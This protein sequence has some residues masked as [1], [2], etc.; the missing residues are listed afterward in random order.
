MQYFFVMLV[1]AL[2]LSPGS[3]WAILNTEFYI[4]V[5]EGLKR[6]TTTLTKVYKHLVLNTDDDSIGQ[7]YGLIQLQLSSYENKDCPLTP[8]N[9]KLNIGV[10]IR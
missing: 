2:F 4:Q 7:I 6:P 10:A 9:S 8:I 3:S 1:L 5:P